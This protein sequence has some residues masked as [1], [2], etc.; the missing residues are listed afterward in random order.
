[1]KYRIQHANKDNSIDFETSKSLSLI[2]QGIEKAIKDGLILIHLEHAGI[3]VG[4][5]FLKNSIIMEVPEK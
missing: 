2:L 4:I 3:I 1:M 5:E